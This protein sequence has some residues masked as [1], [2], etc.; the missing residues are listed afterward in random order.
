LNNQQQNKRP[1]FSKY[2]KFSAFAFQFVAIFVLLSLGGNWL[3][4]RLEYKFPLFT[5]IGVFVALIA[6]FYSLYTFVTKENTDK[7]QPDA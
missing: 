7:D 2:A 1:S 5:L 6:I 4:K 3:D